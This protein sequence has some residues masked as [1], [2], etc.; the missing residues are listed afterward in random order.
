MTAFVNPLARKQ[1]IGYPEA[2]DRIKFATRAILKLSDDVVIS[3]T[4][5]ACREPGCPDIETVLAILQAGRKPLTV[6][7]HIPIP[8]ISEGE[9]TAA[10]LAVAGEKL[11]KASE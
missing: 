10:L 2:I 6:R 9:L 1:K 3:V 8:K 4:E 11:R 7:F 5:L